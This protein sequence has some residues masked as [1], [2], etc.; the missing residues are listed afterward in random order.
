MAI[1]HDTVANLG[2]HVLLAAE[3]EGGMTWR[4]VSC[5]TAAGEVSFHAQ[6]PTL[7]VHGTFDED[8]MFWIAGD[9]RMR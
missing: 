9:L 5:P 2:S 7:V 4:G 8:A 6:G 3:R 1:A